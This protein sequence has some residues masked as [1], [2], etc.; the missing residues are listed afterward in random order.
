MTTTL[1]VLGISGSLRRNSFNSGL[2]RA[3]VTIAPPGMSIT[4][5][6]L[7]DIPLYSEDVLTTGV[8]DAVRK[9]KEAITRS[10]A[11]LIA[12]PEYNYS[13]SGVLKNA[14]DWASRPIKE[15]PLV[16]KPLAIMGAGGRMGTVRAQLALRQVAVYLNMHPLNRPEVLVANAGEKFDAEGNLTDQPTLQSVRGL[17]EA[18][19][20][21]TRR[22]IGTTRGA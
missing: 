2:I 18:L 9:F 15:S 4:P 14:I 1:Q 16:G 19:A 6:D 13:I 22:L 5:F 20:D 17:L 3:A 12:T 7:K 10:D 11:L 8:P 21:W